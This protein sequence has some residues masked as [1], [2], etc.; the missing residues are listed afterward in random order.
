MA[1]AVHACVL[2]CGVFTVVRLSYFAVIERINLL[3]ADLSIDLKR[4]S[5]KSIRINKNEALKAP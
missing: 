1:R 4:S 3:N 5:N 2:A